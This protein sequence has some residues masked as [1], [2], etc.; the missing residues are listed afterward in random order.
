MAAVETCNALPAG[1]LAG[2]AGLAAV[3]RAYEE[4]FDHLFL[5]F[6]SGRSRTEVQAAARERLGNDAA[7]ERAIVAAELREIAPL[8]LEKVLDALG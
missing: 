2:G 7:S 6:A 3:N 8:R 1:R 4:R 5:I